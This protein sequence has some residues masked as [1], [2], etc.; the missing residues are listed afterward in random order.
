MNSP[1]TSPEYS[2]YHLPQQAKTRTESGNTIQNSHPN[3]ADKS[4]TTTNAISASN[5]F[6]SNRLTP[7]TPTNSSTLNSS[8]TVPLSPTITHNN[9]NINELISIPPTTTTTAAAA[10]FAFSSSSSPDTIA[11][12]VSALS[13]PVSSNPPPPL[14][15]NSPPAR[16]SS[17]AD[18]RPLLETIDRT[19]PS[20][21]YPQSPLSRIEGAEILLEIRYGRRERS[22]E[23]TVELESQAGDISVGKGA[24]KVEGPRGGALWG[25]RLRA[26]TK[27]SVKLTA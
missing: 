7:V 20:R 23:G 17:F 22:R 25:S 15:P 1:P 6:D 18:I 8:K 11:N 24:D 2:T 10:A 14:T 19:A 9:L 16:Q 13:L 3:P 4:E 21:A 26:T 12:A 27:R 5:T